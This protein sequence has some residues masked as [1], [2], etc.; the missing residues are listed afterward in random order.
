[1]VSN[2]FI[3]PVVKEKVKVKLDFAISTGALQAPPLAAP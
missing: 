1:M 3:I 2:F